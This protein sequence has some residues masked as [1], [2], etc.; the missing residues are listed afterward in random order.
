MR[1]KQ[2]ML[3]DIKSIT[4]IYMPIKFFLKLIFLS[5]KNLL[6]FA[7]GGQVCSKILFIEV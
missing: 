4:L 7:A 3:L 2:K 5:I 1:L 6:V